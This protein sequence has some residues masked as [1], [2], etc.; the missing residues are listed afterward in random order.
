MISEFTV[1]VPTLPNV[2]DQQV[3]FKVTKFVAG[4]GNTGTSYTPKPLDVIDPVVSGVAGAITLSAEPATPGYDTTDFV[5]NNINQRGLFRWVAEIGFE[6][7][8]GAVA[9][10]GIGVQMV[11]ANSQTQISATTHHK[12]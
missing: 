10:N 3:Q 12:E 6:L 2:T 9:T 11:T 7:A 8:C 1:G 5:N 4:A